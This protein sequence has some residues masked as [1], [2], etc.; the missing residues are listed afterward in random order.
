MNREYLGK[1]SV[2]PK[3]AA[4][5]ALRLSLGWIFFTSG[6]SKL[7]EHGFAYSQA[8]GYL[9]SAVPI[10]TPEL[11]L[12]FPEIIGLPGLLLVKAGT[13]LVEPLMQ[14]F[15]STPFIGAL[16][17]L[18]ELFIGLSLILG[19]L[20][21]V[22]SGLGV[23]LMLMFYYGNAEWSHGLLNADMVY[24]I[25]FLSLIGLRA[26]EKLSLDSYI[27]EKMKKDDRVLRALIGVR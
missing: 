5:L 15:A 11:A 17:V 22:G 26:E 23:L 3:T 6:L 8:S 21:R 10:T 27:S 12:S 19:L 4:V 18:S 20:T 13:I 9:N 1:I 16:V 7:V 2:K 14:I 25:L 24:L